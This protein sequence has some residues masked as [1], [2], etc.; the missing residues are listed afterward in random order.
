M[1]NELIKCVQDIVMSN[2]GR[3]Y[4]KEELKEIIGA[5][6]KALEDTLVKNGVVKVRGFGIFETQYHPEKTI[7]H[8]KTK[9]EIIVSDYNS[10]KF[11]AGTSLKKEVNE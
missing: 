8:P 1:N 9:E 4:A 11:R 10:I 2:T 3:K 5:T 7:L 6:F